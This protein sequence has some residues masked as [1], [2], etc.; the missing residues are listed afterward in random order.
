MTWQD[1]RA[2]GEA[3]ELEREV[4]EDLWR[5]WLGME[6]PRNPSYPP[7]RLHWLQ[8]HEPEALRSTRWLLQPKDF[9]NL[10]LTGVAGSDYWSSKGLVHLETGE[11]IEAYRRLLGVD[12]ALAPPCHHP[13]R[14]LGPLAEPAAGELGVP[15]GIPV[16][17]GW[18]DAMAGM[19][20]TGALTQDGLAFDIAGTSE[21]VGLTAAHA[22]A[23]ADGALIAPVLDSERRVIYGPT[24][25]GGAALEWFLRG[26]YPAAERVDLA[27][28]DSLLPSSSEGLLFLPYLEGERAPLW[29]PAA[30]GVFFRIAASHTRAHFLRAVLEGVAFSVRHVLEVAETAA[31]APA[32]EVRVSGGGAQSAGWNAIKAAALN[33]PVRPTLVRDAGTLGAAI[34]AALVASTFRDAREASAA[35]VRL[36]PAIAP[37]DAGRYETLYREYRDLYRA[38]RPLFRP[39]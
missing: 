15:A 17:T 20:G 33:R 32:T 31:R 4:G 27:A 21:I 1:T 9:V 38:L 12:P 24:Q 8:R 2:V 6:L 23:D 13:H 36:G 7:A 37:D 25:S 18:S 35:M 34:L 10:R 29:D 26:F 19:L 39:V 5:T 3:A 22:P 11:P 28:I 30:R 16:A 14:C